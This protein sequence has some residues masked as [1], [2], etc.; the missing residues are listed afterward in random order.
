MAPSIS[1]PNPEL[2]AGHSESPATTLEINSP[3]PNNSDL[4][5]VP[6]SPIRQQLSDLGSSSPASTPQDPH[7]GDF[8]SINEEFSDDEAPIKSVIRPTSSSAVTTSSSDES[9]FRKR[10]R[11]SADE[12]Y[13]N[14]NP[15]LYG[16]RRSG[17]VKNTKRTKTILSDSDDSDLDQRPARHRRKAKVARAAK[18]SQRPTPMFASPALEESDE[19][20]VYG[21]KRDKAER[22]RRQ[23]LQ[24][25]D[26]P[27][28]PAERVSSRNVTKQ[29]NYNEEENSL[30]EE[31]LVD[32]T[33]GANSMDYSYD[34]RPGVEKVLNYR[35][36]D[37]DDDS[38]P[39]LE[40]FEF[41]IWWRGSAPYHATWEDWAGLKDRIGSKR[42]SNYMKSEI[43]KRWS[44]LH[45]P[46]ES[47]EE[48]EQASIDRNKNIESIAHFQTVQRIVDEHETDVALEYYVKWNQ[49]EYKH[50]TWEP[51]ELVEEIAP[52]ELK[53][54]QEQQRTPPIIAK[55]TKPYYR[56]QL[57]EYLQNQPAYIVNGTLRD[58]QL[59]GISRM[60]MAWSKGINTI[61]GDEMGLGKTVQT[62][63]LMSWLKNECDIPGPFLVVAP[64][65]VIGAWEDTL[66]NWTPDL[67]WV[68]YMGDPES[69]DIIEQRDL[70]VNPANPTHIKA[71]VILT[72][73][74]MFSTGANTFKSIRWQ[75]LAVDEAHRLKNHN[76]KLYDEFMKQD[77]ASRLL[78]TGTPFQ[79]DHKELVAL[80]SFLQPEQGLENKYDFNTTDVQKQAA[81]IEDLRTKLRLHLIRRVKEEVASDL[82]PKTEKIIRVELADMQLE[83]YKNILTRNYQALAQASNGAK[84]GLNN[85]MIELKKASIH[86]YLFDG[87]E[88]HYLQGETSHPEILRGLIANSGK[89]MLLDQ[90][91]TKLKSEGHRVLVFS[92]FVGMLDV[93][94]QYM[95]RRD[96]KFQRL[97]GQTATNARNAAMSHFNA[98]ESD[99]FVFLLSTRA[100]G[101]GINLYT[102][103]TVILFDSDW[104]PQMDLQA[105]ARAHRI[106]Q[107]KPVTVYR[108][109]SR[110]TVEEEIL[111]RARNKLLL[112][113]VT[114]ERGYTD[115]QTK[116]YRKTMAAHGANSEEAKNA[117]DISRILRKRGQKMFEQESNQK[118][119]EDLDINAVLEGAEEQR[120]EQPQGVGGMNDE[121][122]LRSFTYTDV[123]VNLDWDQIIPKAD[124]DRIVEDEEKK[125]REEQARR[126]EEYVRSLTMPRKSKARAETERNHRAAK[127]KAKDKAQEK[128]ASTAVSDEDPDDDDDDGDSEK[129]LDPKRALNDKE[130]RDLVQAFQTYGYFDDRQDDIIRMAHLQNRDIDVIKATVEE[131]LDIARN[132]IDEHN[133]QQQVRTE[134]GEKLGSKKNQKAVMFEHRS[135]QRLNADT[136][137]RRPYE[138]RLLKEVVDD[139]TD[140]PN[141]KITEA[142]KGNDF[143]VE[144]GPREDGMLAIGVVRHG[145]GKW[146]EIEDDTEL[147]MKDKFFLNEAHVAEQAKREKEGGKPKKPAGPHLIRRI[148]YLMDVIVDRLT[149]GRDETAHESV[150]NHH[151]NNKRDIPDDPATRQRQKRRERDMKRKLREQE[152]QDGGKSQLYGRASGSPAMSHGPR[153]KD[154]S[155]MNGIEPTYR[156]NR[157]SASPARR[158]RDD[159]KSYR[160]RLSNGDR[161]RSP[162]ISGSRDSTD[163]FSDGL[164]SHRP[165]PN[166]GQKESKLLD[167]SDKSQRHG[168]DASSSRKRKSDQVGDN[169]EV[170][171]RP[172]KARIFEHGAQ[173]IYRNHTSA[174]VS[175]NGVDSKQPS[176]GPSVPAKREGPS[177]RDMFRPT[178]EKF[179]GLFTEFRRWKGQTDPGS[180]KKA[181]EQMYNWLEEVIH[182]IEQNKAVFGERLEDKC[183]EHVSKYYWFGASPGRE[184]LRAMADRVREQIKAQRQSNAGSK[185]EGKMATGNPVKV[186]V[187]M[188]NGEAKKEA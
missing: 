127:D 26:S 122:F 1:D 179:D 47:R 95:R 50:C 92:G 87:V 171:E 99:D 13:I 63:S 15:E 124:R 173:P 177:F 154:K 19:E 166:I 22:R 185:T 32:T 156:I 31:D 118:K 2:R 158:H 167:R 123:D 186:G 134:K 182:F 144:W 153:E 119:L 61:L 141:F 155:H 143:D 80:L 35:R 59:V 16:V 36:K 55:P 149:G 45:D 112:E 18:S 64:K 8:N 10:K 5:S 44:V 120:T 139:V 96:H 41:L 39:T 114:I 131:F 159:M 109:V 52:N 7:D 73:P 133:K 176:S 121:E 175:G 72:T 108:F 148:N 188:T 60:A 157:R 3:S 27:I 100:G 110:D 145:F 53:R 9:G 43:V 135:Q 58:F 162:L 21:S 70:F 91:L 11:P 103:D 81:Q 180:K 151:R 83:Y 51:A 89:M 152:Q 98:H 78:I 56:R 66:D 17:R 132:K 6:Q 48:K 75:F 129:E 33:H 160:H 178:S 107:K 169:H 136:L 49:L 165:K 20:D 142:I 172:E 40:K 57:T 161:P 93:L 147:N 128:A 137:L 90:L 38:S 138:L 163:R 25:R 150:L 183:W 29:V 105:M 94:S 84:I 69:R 34:T 181:S 140:I 86:P 146:R 68:T 174:K 111:E 106:G 187:P 116:E 77:V 71:N 101:L 62:V 115:E 46:E 170:R 104:N 24:H 23:R 30:D 28:A 37:D 79:N 113:Y 168:S 97:D 42:V 88:E 102:A 4:S 85:I 164:K 65:G 76:N 126:D 67:H 74:E 125:K 184:K 117:E 14:E 12:D 54:F 130:A 82:P